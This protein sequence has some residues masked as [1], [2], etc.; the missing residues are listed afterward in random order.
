MQEVLGSHVILHDR[1][2]GIEPA[3]TILKPT[4][5]WFNRRYTRC[6]E[7]LLKTRFIDF[8]LLLSLV[9]GVL[10]KWSHLAR[11]VRLNAGA[12]LG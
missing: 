7:A 8:P 11:A 6:Q 5:N 2:R 9:R 3:S 12:A 4:A 1:V 10:E